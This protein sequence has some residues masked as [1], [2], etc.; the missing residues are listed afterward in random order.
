MAY[1]NMANIYK[2]MGKLKEA[3]ECHK[4]SIEFNPSYSYPYN[5]LGNIYND[6]RNYD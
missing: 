6:E 1:Y 4:K 5:N 3:K 2:T